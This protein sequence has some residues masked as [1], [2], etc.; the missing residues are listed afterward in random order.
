MTEF[1]T[2]LSNFVKKSQTV[3]SLSSSSTDTEYPS[4]KCV[5]DNVKNKLEQ[6]DI[7]ILN[8]TYYSS[9]NTL[10]DFVTETVKTN[11][12]IDY[13]TMSITTSANVVA[14]LS[15]QNSSDYQTLEITFNCSTSN[16]S[17]III[18]DEMF[19]NTSTPIVITLGPSETLQLED[20]GNSSGGNNTITYTYRR[21][22]E[23]INKI[24]NIIYP[25]GA[26]YI[27]LNDTRPEILFGGRWSGLSDKFLLGASETYAVGSTGGSAT[28][29][30]TSAQSGV[31]AHNHT[32]AHT[33]TTYKAN[34]T[35]RKPGT[36][37]A[38]NYVTSI[39]A[40]A[41]NT[42]KTS[43]NNT[44]AN[45]SQAHEN[46]PPYISVYMWKRTA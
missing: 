24:G 7:I 25:V 16:Y 42:T 3:T 5:Y 20:Y 18:N 13:S 39:T 6:D 43:N 44:A 32:Y 15:L 34:T 1:R 46:M 12:T 38:V 8:D 10:S 29:T 17:G 33:D 26:I 2:L 11:A 28:V 21:K 41:N 37:T 45:A 36:S 27:S 4:A 40:T 35:S 22:A 9:S 19:A 14:R 30:L 31:P 23:S